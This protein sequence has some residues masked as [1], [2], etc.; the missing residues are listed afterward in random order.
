MGSPAMMD[1]RPTLPKTK[2]GS[3]SSVAEWQ[4]YAEHCERLI[5]YWQ[6]IAVRQ[7]NAYAIVFDDLAVTLA[8]VH[9]MNAASIVQE[10]AK[11]RG[12]HIIHDPPVFK[13]PPTKA[14]TGGKDTTSPRERRPDQLCR[15]ALQLL[16]A[17]WPAKL[18]QGEIKARLSMTTQE[19]VAVKERLIENGDLAWAGDSPMNRTYGY[20]R[21]LQNGEK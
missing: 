13:A 11:S 9:Q 18:T 12:I 6:D 14:A 15:D 21:R 10:Y 3:G 4:A 16:E 2:P 7:V 17:I 19:W 8:G 20:R 5:A 1:A